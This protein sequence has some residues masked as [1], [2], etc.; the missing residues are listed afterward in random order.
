MAAAEDRDVA[1]FVSRVDAVHD[2]VTALREGRPG[3][4]AD[5]DAAL[6]AQV[7]CGAVAAAA[8]STI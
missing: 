2:L 8:V 6:A 3:A 4:E 1:A 5:A 7:R